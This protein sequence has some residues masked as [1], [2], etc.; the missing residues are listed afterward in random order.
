MSHPPQRRHVRLHRSQQRYNG[1]QVSAPTLAAGRREEG[2]RLDRQGILILNPHAGGAGP[3]LQRVGELAAERPWLTVCETARPGH[4][5]E[6]AARA[7]RDGHTLVVAAGGDGM[8]SEVVDGL[9]EDFGKAALGIIPAG[10][11][12]DFARTAGIPA[13]VVQAFAVLDAGHVRPVD[14]IRATCSESHHVL[15]MATGGFSVELG[16]RITEETKGRWGRL[17]YAVTA[18]QCL[19]EIPI[20]EATIRIDQNEPFHVRTPV[21]LVDNGQWAGGLHLAPAASPDDCL[22]DVAIITASTL[23]ESTALLARFLAGTHLESDGL[24][25]Q[26]ARSI[27]IDATPP[28]P[29]HSDGEAV[30]SS[31]VRF[32]LL[33]RVL[34]LIVPDDAQAAG[35][36]PA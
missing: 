1:W 10:T 13:D 24:L 20:Y 23:A 4:A 18:L 32:D 26:R 30:A 25:F 29:F 16:K 35:E 6:L 34:P 21:L 14:V 12:N 36:K 2:P 7:V 31:P 11:A 28:M 3:H 27:Q 8:I 33:P 5:T 9:A 22:L 15:N 19:G 17:A